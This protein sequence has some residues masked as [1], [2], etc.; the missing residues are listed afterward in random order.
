MI[1]INNQASK[2]IRKILVNIQSLVKAAPKE[3][4]C[5][6]GVFILYHYEN[7]PMQYLAIFH[8]CKIDN[9]QMKNYDIFLIFA[10]NID[11]GYTLERVPTIYVLEQK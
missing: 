9:F 11:C 10:Q 1:K 5:Q 4:G 2:Q 8:G 7:M 3:E 6:F